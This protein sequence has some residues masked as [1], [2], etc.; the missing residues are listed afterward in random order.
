M[1]RVWAYTISRS[2]G[3][4]ELENLLNAGNAFVKRWTAHDQRLSASFEIFRK[5]I[6][7]VKVNEEVTGAS[8]CSIDKLTRFVKETEQTFHVELMNRL[9]VAHQN[10][11]NIE[12]THASKIK[13]LLNQGTV[14]ENT[15]VYNTSLAND[16]ELM[17]WEQPLKNTW[18]NK[19]LQNP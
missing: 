15:V 14:T 6:I 8:G 12:I 4:P 17:N 5:K 11:E 9:L 1:N 13:E 10:G 18:L 2:L 3:D 16:S 19:Y 7:L